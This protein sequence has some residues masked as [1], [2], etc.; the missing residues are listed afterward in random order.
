MKFPIYV[1]V[2]SIYI[3]RHVARLFSCLCWKKS[4]NIIGL[5]CWLGEA[6]QS[7]A[8][9]WFRWWHLIEVDFLGFLNNRNGSNQRRTNEMGVLD[10]DGHAFALYRGTIAPLDRIEHR[11]E[12]FHRLGS[13]YLRTKPHRLLHLPGRA[14]SVEDGDGFVMDRLCW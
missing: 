9:V 2:S 6:D 8:E 1:N 3:N 12:F 4:A 11:R 14:N 7:L 5:S 13:Y 10:Y